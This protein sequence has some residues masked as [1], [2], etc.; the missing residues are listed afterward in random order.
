MRRVR[1]TGGLTILCLTAS[2]CSGICGAQEVFGTK[3]YTVSKVA[4]LSFVPAD[5]SQAFHTSG[6]LGRFGAVNTDQHFYATV[7]IPAGANIDYIGINNLNDGTPGVITAT[8]RIRTGGFLITIGQVSNTP[9]AT[10]VTDL[11]PDPLNTHLAGL[12]NAVLILDVEIASSPNL[13]F[14]GWVGVWWKR[15][16]SSSPDVDF[17]DVPADHPFHDY[18]EALYKAG[19]TA[20][21]ADG[22]FGVDDPITRGQMAVFLSIALGLHWPF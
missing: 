10:W 1:K 15:L 2:L 8:L 11:N 9:H 6:S 16:V 4:A 22:R 17:T 14:F 12:E 13:Q 5:S 20:G 19:I 7:D 3:D 21:Y 18:V